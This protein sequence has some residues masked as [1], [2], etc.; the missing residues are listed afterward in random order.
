MN[1]IISPIETF[2]WNTTSD[3]NVSTWGA[4]TWGSGWWGDSASSGFAYEDNVWRWSRRL[5]RQKCNSISIEISFSSSDGLGAV[6]T[7]IMLE[8]GNRN[9]MDKIPTRTFGV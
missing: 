6:P 9:T 2:T 8:L 4:G 7:V 3:L 5:S 1:E